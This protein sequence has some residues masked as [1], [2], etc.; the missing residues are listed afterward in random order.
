MQLVPRLPRDKYLAQ[1]AEIDV[2][3]DP[4][5]YTGGITTA[6]SL[7]MGV[8]VLTVAGR[9]TASRQG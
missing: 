7:W 6:D 8:P 3:L 1:Y 2:A 9:T 4:F 5:P